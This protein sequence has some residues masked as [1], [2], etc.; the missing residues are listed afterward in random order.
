MRG[1]ALVLLAIAAAS[2]G[3][4]RPRPPS[5]LVVVVDALR[6]DHLAAYGYERE[7]SPTITRLA[8]QGARFAHAY[9]QGPSTVPTHSSLFT[10]RFPFQHGSYDVR[11]PLRE[12]EL[13]LAEF[14]GA[15]GYRTFAVAS[16]VRFHP[17]SGWSQGFED[18]EIVRA[19]DKARLGAAVT[20]TA[21]RLLARDDPRPVFGFVHYLG[22]HQ[23]YA[24]PP[25]HRTRWHPGLAHPRPEDTG[26]F[27]TAHGGP[28]QPV[29]AEVLAYLKGLYDGEISH[30]DPELGRLLAGLV[31]A[32][33]D[34]DT[35]VVL[36]ADH[37]EQ[38]KEHGGLSHGGGLHEELL[39]VPL[40]VRWPGRVPPGTVVPR[41][42]QTV[43]VFPTLASL[44]GFPPPPGLAGRD[45]RAALLGEPQAPPA[46]DDAVFAQQ[47]P[48]AWAV[49]ATV[50]GRRL[51]Y[52]SREGAPVLFDLS[53]DPWGTVD[54]LP[55]F[56]AEAARLRTVADALGAGRDAERPPAL[57]TVPEG[58][59]RQL[60][61]LGYVDEAD[62][63]RP[64]AR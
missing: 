20:S 46:D 53:S 35:I 14:L 61:A 51:K 19:Y 60:R 2:C 39:R 9:A 58:V 44:A 27:L 1:V 16:S 3:A 22:P 62:A 42:A 41:L 37:G 33:S 54:V 30:L 56:P 64:D 47:A 50:G 15:R 5:I 12:E 63:V 55:R 43:D 57:E 45:H 36:T 10:G 29:D 38:F 26:A 24:P 21:L 8:A 4:P 11:R 25:P 59:R 52:E 48:G 34:R 32:G 13:T 40:L 7:T 18:Y 6:P 49:I 17:L 28:G 31:Y 23:P